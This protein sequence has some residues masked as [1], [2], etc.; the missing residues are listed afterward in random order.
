MVDEF[1]MGF[2]RDKP[3]DHGFSFSPMSAL[4]PHHDGW[5]VQIVPL[6]VGVLQFPVS[7]AL[8]CDKLGQALRRAIESYSEDLNVA[9][10]ATGGVSHQVRGERCGYNNPEW[11]AQ[12]PRYVGQ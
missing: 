7:S 1:D 6:Q 5:S 3:L 12:Y 2:F 10:V 8:R 11:D 9:I 4:L